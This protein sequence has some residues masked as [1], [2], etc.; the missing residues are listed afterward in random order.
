MQSAALLKPFPPSSSSCNPHRWMMVNEPKP[1]VSHGSCQPTIVAPSA[2]ATT[3]AAAS[4]AAATTTGRDRRHDRHR[5]H[6]HGLATLMAV[7]AAA[8]TTALTATAATAATATATAS[9]TTDMF[10]VPGW[11]LP[12]KVLTPPQ[13]SPGQAWTWG[14]WAFAGRR[15]AAPPLPPRGAPGWSNWS[16]SRVQNCTRSRLLCCSNLTDGEGPPTFGDASCSAAA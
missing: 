10:G 5:A 9:A 13:P 3:T 16:S 8:A 12:C 6:R 2:P 4:S 15:F 14:R 11:V 7:A 1:E